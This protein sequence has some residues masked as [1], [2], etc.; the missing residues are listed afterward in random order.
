[1]TANAS[2][3]A[4]VTAC[5]HEKK[6]NEMLA[7]SP[8]ARCGNRAVPP[9]TGYM[10][11]SSACTSAR[12]MMA[13]APISQAM[14]EAAPMR[15]AA[16]EERRRGEGAQ[17]PSGADNRGLGGPGGP[18]QPDLTLKPDITRFDVRADLN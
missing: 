5:S 9:A 14:T 16:P 17:Q 8:K 11:P 6:P 12:I 2:I 13:T 1:M 3:G 10:P 4:T 15:W 18:D 7:P